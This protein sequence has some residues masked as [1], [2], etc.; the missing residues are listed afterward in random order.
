MPNTRATERRNAKGFNWPRGR[1][2][3]LRRKR[4]KGTT[5]PSGKNPRVESLKAEEKEERE[6]KKEEGKT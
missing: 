4:I 3:E 6:K 1:P 2:E 5:H